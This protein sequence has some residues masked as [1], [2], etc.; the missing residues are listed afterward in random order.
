M[1]FLSDIHWRDSEQPQYVSADVI[2]LILSENRTEIIDLVAKTYQ[3]FY[4]GFALN[5]DT[6]SLK[7]P[8]KANSR[9]NALPAYVGQEINLA[10]MKWVA[11]FPDNVTRNKQRASAIIIINSFETGYPLALLDGTQIS[12]ARTAASAA[13]AARLLN[14]TKSS[15]CFAIYGAGIINRDLVK[16]LLDDGWALPR[17]QIRD[18]D[19]ESKAVF[20]NFCTELGCETEQFILNSAPNECDLVSFATTALD[21]WY[22]YEIR[23]HQTILHISLRD[24][25][26]NRLGGNVRNIV[27][28]VSHAVKAN[29]SL[30]LLQQQD[31]SIPRIENFQ[32]LLKKEKVSPQATV[33]AA[34]GMGMLDVALASFVMDEAQKMGEVQTVS[35]IL[36]KFNRW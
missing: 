18:P 20:E 7:F 29:T 5:P 25:V 24:I 35:G 27:D 17:V 16:F 2:E 19:S 30:H 11:S 6:Y 26:P 12:S 15:D 1:T 33:V 23:S 8:Q 3:S 31:G 21:P 9:I 22:E 32:S 36:P 4:D 34:F 28:D 14:P 13:L 10:G